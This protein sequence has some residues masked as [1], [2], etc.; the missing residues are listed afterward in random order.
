MGG[1]YQVGHINSV[2][3]PIGICN[4]HFDTVFG[5]PKTTNAV[6]AWHSSFIATVGC[7]HPNIW[8]F[9]SAIKREQGLIEVRQTKYLAG[10]K[11]TKAK[12]CK[13]TKGPCYQNRPKL[14]F[15]RRVSHHFSRGAD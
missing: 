10:D 2:C 1:R 11:P 15:L 13:I 4:Y 8:K 3:S 5:L 7:H 6:E 12:R 14:Q 9:I